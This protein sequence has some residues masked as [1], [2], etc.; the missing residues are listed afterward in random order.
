MSF[1]KLVSAGKE[2][3]HVD[4]DVVRYVYQPLEELYLVLITNK[5]SNILQDLGHAASLCPH[6]V[7]SVPQ[8]QRGRAFPVCL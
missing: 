4:T 3:T 1:T 6:R 5:S 7:G 8:P 2:H